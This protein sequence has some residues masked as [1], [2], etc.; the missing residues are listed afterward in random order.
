VDV[1]P[2]GSWLAFDA[3]GSGRED[4]FVIRT[5][6][7]GRRQLTDDPYRDRFPKWSPDGK[8]ICFYSNRN[9]NYEI[10]TIET[11]GSGLQQLTDTPGQSVNFPTWSPDGSRMAYYNRSEGLSYIFNP[12]KPWG[13]QTPI[14]LP[15]LENELQL[16]A[17]SW[18]PDGRSIAGFLIAA[19]RRHSGPAIYDLESKKYLGPL[20]FKG[21]GPGSTVWLPDSSGILFVGAHP[22]SGKQGLYMADRELRQ[23]QEILSDTT[24]EVP[25][26]TPNGQSIYF[27]RR[28]IEADIWLLTLSDER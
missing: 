25:K 3:F 8:K 23:V 6:G 4:I 19:G 12:N 21:A 27:N 18:S 11:D 10:W 13:E 28:I 2:D 16:A 5:D 20:E 22:S 14:P 17:N 24:V 9:G 26:V 7:T 1:S 15:S